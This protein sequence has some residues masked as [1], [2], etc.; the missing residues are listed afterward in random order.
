MRVVLDTNV[1]ISALIAQ[2]VCSELLEHC[3]R[4][5][6]VIVSDDI[7]R[8]LR[9][10]LVGKFKYPE[11]D[12]AKAL[13]LV[14]SIAET[15]APSNLTRPVCRDRDDDMVL[16]TAVS[17]NAACIVTGD[18]DLLVLREYRGIAI[19]RPAEFIEFEVRNK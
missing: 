11:Q 6:R 10:H 13:E 4:Q 16:G 8:E 18:A 17:G 14:V 1:L 19:L 2:G 3:S 9:E 12:A 5:H 15:V 7:L